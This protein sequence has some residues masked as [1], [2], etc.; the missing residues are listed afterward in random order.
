MQPNLL[1]KDFYNEKLISSGSFG[2]VHRV[3]NK[4]TQEKLYAIKTMT[5]QSGKSQDEIQKEIDLWKKL[6]SIEKT[7]AI[8]N[9]YGSKTESLGFTGIS[10]HMIFDYFPKSMQSVIE[11][12]KNKKI[13]YPFP[14]EKISCFADSLINSLAFLQSMKV[15]HRDLKPANLLLDEEF[16]Q[17]YLI[18]LGESKEITGYVPSQTK[19]EMTLVGTAK[20]LSPEL[21]NARKNDEEKVKVNPFKSDVFSF[22]LALLELGALE[23]P[24]QNADLKIWEKNIG[25]VI[26]SFNESYQPLMKD[27]SEM[28]SLLDFVKTMKK[29]LRINPDERPDFSRLFYRNLK[30]ID[31]DRFRKHILLE[32]KGKYDL[33]SYFYH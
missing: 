10:H 14:F 9:F 15:C 19:N 24:K 7:K 12:L 29:C 20:Y 18:D 26:K 13:P 3:Q 27:D 17:I 6:Q 30:N 8:P 28:E 23:V 2:T 21:Y 4:A 32:E 11:D 33:S 31:A 16:N 1:F 5:F 25:K 22:G